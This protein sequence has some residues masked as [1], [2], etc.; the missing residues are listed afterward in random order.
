MEDVIK[1]L[2]QGRGS[3]N[4]RPDTGIPTNFSQGDNGGPV[5]KMKGIHKILQ[6]QWMGR[7]SHQ[8]YGS[9]KGKAPMEIRQAPQWDDD[10]DD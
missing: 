10:E 2:T 6:E 9:G 1:Y 7:S 3:W 8:E 4:Y 5:S